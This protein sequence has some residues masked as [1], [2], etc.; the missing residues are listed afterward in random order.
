[1]GVSRAKQSTPKVNPRLGVAPVRTATPEE[2]AQLHAIWKASISLLMDVCTGRASLADGEW[3]YELFMDARYVGTPST[4]EGVRERLR[5]SWWVEESDILQQICL[6]IWQKQLY[7]GGLCPGHEKSLRMYLG[8]SMRDWLLLQRVCSRQIGWEDEYQYILEEKDSP[9]PEMP[10]GLPFLLQ[11][12]S[13]FSLHD[14]YMMYLYGILG[15][16]YSQISY[17][18]LTSPVLASKLVRG[19]KQKVEEVYV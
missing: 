19:M 1:M 9:L 17:I 7:L 12:H 11:K 10:L 15:L 4:I 8:R 6:Y 14:R 5:S 16:S 13:A 18:L 2:Q 3:F